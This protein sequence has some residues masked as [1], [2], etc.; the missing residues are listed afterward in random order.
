[1]AT[2]T[3][4][5]PYTRSDAS[6]Q[7]DVLDELDWEGHVRSNE[8]GITVKDGIVTLSGTVDSYL[9]RIA[10]QDAAHRV[11]GVR[12]VANEIE[13]RLPAFAERT[14][15]DIARA[16]LNALVW[17]AAIPADKVEVTVTDGWVTLKGEVEWRF[18]RDAAERVVR[19]LAGVRGI[20]M[21]VTVKA[22]PVPADVRQKIEQALVRNAQI[23]A[24]RVTVEVNGSVA[25]L[26]G[27]VRSYIEKQAAER[28]ALS[29][30]GITTVENHIAI[31]PFIG[32]LNK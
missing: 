2:T 9:A 5:V 20:S 25:V 22:H 32:L 11:H 17:D 7:Q 21:L 24:K 27:T 12:A 1:M 3:Q 14:D 31:D 6:I 15:E 19:R 28:S 18:Q 29:A 13:V 16:V 30:P 23:D 4:A 10:A 8:I 26:K